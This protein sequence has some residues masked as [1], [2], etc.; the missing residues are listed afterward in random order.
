M[1]Q[2]YTWHDLVPG[3]ACLFDEFIPTTGDI[4]NSW[5]YCFTNPLELGINETI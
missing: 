5:L 4:N 3:V 2:F 1:I